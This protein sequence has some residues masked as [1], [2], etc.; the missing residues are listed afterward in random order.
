M[1]NML[2]LFGAMAILTGTLF[3]FAIVYK[4]ETSRNFFGDL[5]NDLRNK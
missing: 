3:V 2:G 1:D 5:F 4:R